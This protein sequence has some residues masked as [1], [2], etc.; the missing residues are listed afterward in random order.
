MPISDAVLTL[1]GS[2]TSTSSPLTSTVNAAS[3]C[4]ISGTTLTIT[5]MTTGQVAVG[6]QVLGPGVTANTFITALGSGAGLTGTYTVSQ[7]QTVAGATALTFA[8]NTAGDAYCA[9]G[10][11]YSNLEIDFG[12]PSSGGS[13]P[14]VPAFPSL[15]EKGYTFPNVPVGQGGVQFGMHIVVTAPTNLLTSVN[16]EVCTSSTASALVGSSPNPIAARTLTLAQLQVAGAHY[17]IPVSGFAVLEFL[18]VYMALTGTDPTI[19]TLWIY[20]GPSSGGEQ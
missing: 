9:A 7:S 17:F 3:S 10:S 4:A 6:M 19:G 11:Q 15:T 12:V 16:F 13:F 18:R 5:T 1:H 8:P 2:G 14:W 20:W